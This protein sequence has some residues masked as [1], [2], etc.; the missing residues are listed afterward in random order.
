MVISAELSDHSAIVPWFAENDEEED[1]LIL[2]N[3]AFGS[4]A[5][6]FSNCSFGVLG[7]VFH[8]PKDKKRGPNVLMS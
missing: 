2:A 1:C 7:S 8:V 4:K 3:G 6:I 5:A